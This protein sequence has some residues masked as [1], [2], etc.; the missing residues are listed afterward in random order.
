MSERAPKPEVDDQESLKTK[1]DRAEQYGEDQREIYDSSQYGEGIAAGH[2][3]LNE[4]SAASAPANLN[5]KWDLEDGQI[6]LSEAGAFGAVGLVF[7]T[8][9]WKAIMARA[10]KAVGQ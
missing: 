6:S 7:V 10:K 4:G 9:L 8:L 5:W 2:P 3:G 1:N